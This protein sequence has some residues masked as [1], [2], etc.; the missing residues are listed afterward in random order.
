MKL[1][2]LFVL[3]IMTFLSLC[4]FSG[5]VWAHEND[6]WQHGWNSW[7]DWDNWNNLH[8]W[9]D[10]NNAKAFVIQDSQDFF[11]KGNDIQDI[12]VDNQATTLWAFITNNGMT[13]NVTAPNKVVITLKLIS[14][15]GQE[16]KL[17]N[18]IIIDQGKLLGST[19]VNLP[20]GRWKISATADIIGKDKNVTYT[21][22]YFSVKHAR[23]LLLTPAE[24]TILRGG[25]Q[26]F[27]ANLI[28][29]DGSS[30]DV[31]ERVIWTSL[32]QQVAS[33]NSQGLATGNSPGT[34]NIQGKDTISG[35][36]SQTVQLTVNADRGLEIV[37]TPPAKINV[38]ETKEFRANYFYY[39][40]G[41]RIISDVTNWIIWSSSDSAIASI[42]P[43]NYFS[44][45]GVLA[46]GKKPGICTI[47][48][49]NFIPLA[50]FDWN[51]YTATMTLEVEG[52]DQLKLEPAPSKTIYIGDTVQYKA[53]L[54]HPDQTTDDVTSSAQSQWKSSDPSV[55]N[56]D[57]N[58]TATGIKAGNTTITITYNGLTASAT[59]NVQ[60][61]SD[62]QPTVDHFGFVDSSGSPSK[63]SINLRYDVDP[64]N[65]AQ[66][67]WAY[68]GEPMHLDVYLQAYTKG[69]DA[70]N[71]YV[72]DIPWFKD[73]ANWEIASSGSGIDTSKL[74]ASIISD[75]IVENNSILHVP[76]EITQADATLNKVIRDF[77][78]TIKPKNSPGISPLTAINA[79]VP[80][81]ETSSY[82]LY[83]GQIRVAQGYFYRTD[84]IAQVYVEKY[85]GNNFV[86]NTDDS[87]T[88]VDSW[89]LSGSAI[90]TPVR[91]FEGSGE[92]PVSSNTSN[93]SL[94]L[95]PIG[96]P[97]YLR[98]V[99]GTLTW[100]Q[101]VDNPPPINPLQKDEGPV[102]ERELP[103]S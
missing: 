5:T 90:N 95:K 76:I 40:N 16:I 99:E 3:F 4:F 11:K 31:S 10:W 53:T 63:P 87:L 19:Q 81:K 44:G 62:Q 41:Q 37:Y 68:I 71:D 12:Q 88:S 56:V 20:A 46:K 55:A 29:Q 85:D 98:V 6:S 58:G 57:S 77:S 22:N 70:I 61:T 91:F 9:D 52:V 36:T 48:A 60:R 75:P 102:W 24:A 8:D 1:K 35:L 28:F 49:I 78:L 80:G 74:S 27:T 66:S 82:T 94:T 84:G 13:K 33:I 97:S 26:Q 64:N 59:L 18:Q 39:N 15:E 100:G 7:E 50:W 79:V 38:G 89:N 93:V 2:K 92:V 69:G 47:S 86:Q 73:I 34:A 43:W 72:W 51:W 32:N 54:I 30:Q 14:Q 96:Y 45:K 23:E 25:T 42:D 67:T 65:V 103:P 21:T 83:G 17:P 101:I